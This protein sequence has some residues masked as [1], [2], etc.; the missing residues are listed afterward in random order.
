MSNAYATGQNSCQNIEGIRS[1]FPFV[2]YSMTSER[3]GSYDLLKP[4]A[5]GGM[6]DVF[7]ASDGQRHVALKVL[8]DQRSSDRE[9]CALFLDEA[10]LAGL[11]SHKNVAQVL[12][13]NI[14]GGRHYLAMEYVHG[15]DLR[16]VLLA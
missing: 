1:G 12:E 7:L 6:A 4:L 8:S 3:L 13:A 15:A 10:R 14:E 9:S 5:Q 16:E 2:G 11:L